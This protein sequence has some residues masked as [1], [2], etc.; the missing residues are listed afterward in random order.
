MNQDLPVS[1]PAS[2]PHRSEPAFFEVPDAVELERSRD[3]GED[4]AGERESVRHRRREGRLL[5]AAG[6]VT[7]R[8]AGGRTMRLSTAA[9]HGVRDEASDFFDRVD[10]V[11]VG[12]MGVAGGRAVSPMAEQLACQDR[13]LPAMTAW[14]AA[15]WCRSRTSPRRHPVS[16]SSRI[17]ATA[18]GQRASLASSPP[19]EPGKLVRVEEAGNMVARVLGYAETGV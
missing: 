13:F 1:Q 5:K 7:R 15:V 14:L 2:N 11:G 16:A 4:R 3:A 8:H 9:P 10:Q 12:M 17:A 19:P 18:S 6:S